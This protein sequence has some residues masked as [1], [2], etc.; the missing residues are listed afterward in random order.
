MS[1]TKSKGLTRDQILHSKDL[2]VLAA[3][4]V[5]EWG[6]TVYV[7]RITVAEQEKL[8]ALAQL[9]KKAKNGDPGLSQARAVCAALRDEHGNRLFEDPTADDSDARILSGKCF[10]AIDRIHAKF[11][12]VNGYGPAGLEELKKNSAETPENASSSS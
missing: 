2:D 12:E 9:D 11:L 10:A 8:W 6:G 5:P 7:T 3:V 4:D 1:K